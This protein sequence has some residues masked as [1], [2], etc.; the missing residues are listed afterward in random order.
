MKIIVDEREI[1]LYDKMNSITTE[2]KTSN[3]LGKM[4]LTLGDIAILTDDDISVCI[5][6]RKSLTDL[7]AS[8]KDGRYEE[9]S[10]RLL[11]ASQMHPHNIIYIIEGLI[12]QL[13]SAA[14]KK[15]VYSAITSL[16]LFKGFSVLRTNSVQE[17]AELILA[18]T[19]K[20]ARNY[21]KNIPLA[22]NIQ[23]NK[24]IPLAG[25]IDI[26]L[27]GPNNSSLSN[28]ESTIV[29]S[30]HVNEVISSQ[31]NTNYVNFVKKVK[32]DNITPENIG[33]IILSQ[34]PGI[35]SITAIAIMKTYGTFPKLMDAIRLQPDCLNTLTCET[36]SKTEKIKSR[37]ISKACIE[38]IKKF[39]L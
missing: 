1:T 14:E 4:V 28:L 2:N 8:I 25:S 30:E 19:D 6:E 31:N 27:A 17:T 16:N 39:L 13:R 21:A 23:L 5:I 37:K 33:E 20:I 36:A 7:L 35:S 10:H 34:I 18:M 38:N 12:T 29:N 22:M 32:K 3:N 11:H 15:L 9:Q 24:N 26:P